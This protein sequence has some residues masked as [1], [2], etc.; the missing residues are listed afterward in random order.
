M[1]LFCA[2]FTGRDLALGLAAFGW[3]IDGVNGLFVQGLSEN[4]PSMATPRKAK[5]GVERFHRGVEGFKKSTRG[6]D[7]ANTAGAARGDGEA[8]DGSHDGSLPA[9]SK[10]E[11]RS[12][13]G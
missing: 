9:R 7:E 11:M 1:E 6:V 13:P 8:G 5:Q 10:T 2:V 4:Q 3:S 12:A